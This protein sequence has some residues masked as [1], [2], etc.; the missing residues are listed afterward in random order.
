MLNFGGVLDEERRNKL[1]CQYVSICND[2]SIIL[3]A[4]Y[5]LRVTLLKDTK[6]LCCKLPGCF[7]GK[8]RVQVGHLLASGSNDT[9]GDLRREW[10]LSGG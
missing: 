1:Y 2:E 9:A 10:R 5:R 8:N 7:R 4:S 6:K 3:S